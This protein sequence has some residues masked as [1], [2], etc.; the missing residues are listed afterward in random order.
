VDHLVDSNVWLRRIDPTY[1]QPD[2]L[3]VALATL[4]RPPNRICIVPQ[5]LYEL[6]VVC[7]RPRANNGLGMRASEAE[8]SLLDLE[9]AYPLIHDTPGLFEEWKRLVVLHQVS[10]KAAHDTRLVAAM[11]VHA[12]RRIVTFN[13]KD[14]ARYGVQVL[15]PDHV[16]GG[17]P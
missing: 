3:R 11:N 15:D 5:N 6:W 4:R 14:F 16:L 12:I 1:S 17:A 7:T 13:V 2:R 10:G 8:E 9:S